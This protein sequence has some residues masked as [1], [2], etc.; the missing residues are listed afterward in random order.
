MKLVWKLLRQHISIPQFTGFFIA[1]LVGMVI[2]MLGIQFYN[3]TQAV[4]YGEDSFMRNDYLIVNK[5]VSTISGLTNNSSGTF[6]EEEIDEFKAQPFTEKVGWFTASTF[7]VR[8]S[9]NIDQFASFSTEM[10]FES[11]PDEFVDITTESWTFSED[12]ENI[13]IILPRNYL[14]LYNFG[15]AQSQQLPQL[16]GGLLGAMQLG[17]QITGNG[18]TR[19]FNGNI[20]G[21]SNRLN[22]ILVPQ[23]FIE[24]A[25]SHFGTGEEKGASRL[26]VEVNNPADDNITS[27][28]QDN[29]YETDQSKLDASKTTYLLK[30]IVGV[31]M[32]IG[33]IISLLAF[34][35]LMLSVFLLVEKNIVKL[36]NLLLIGY[37]PKRVA[38]P[39]QIL[40]FT[41]N[42]AVLVIATIILIIV[43]GQYIGLLENFFPTLQAP[44]ITMAIAVGLGLMLLVSLFSAIA[45]H[46]KIMSIWKRKH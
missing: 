43:R 30:I 23:A 39:Y 12:D 8:A 27:Y 1:N 17:I 40:T 33:L 22:T 29:G 3:D 26:I 14:D 24:W 5:M 36:E 45:I 44:P 37:S 16:S 11:V 31:V 42:I 15:Y 46:S 35:I 10:F 32:T 6:S 25:N 34:Y 19:S 4:Y 2:I 13:P 18:N 28:L 21:F 9:F 41:L 38:L 20:A 7:K